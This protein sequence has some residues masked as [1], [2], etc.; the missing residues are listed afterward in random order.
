MLHHALD[1]DPEDTLI[2]VWS[3]AYKNNDAF[4]AHLANPEIYLYL[5]EHPKLTDDFPV[6]VYG[7]VG[8][9]FRS[10]ERNRYTFN[11]F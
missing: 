5:Q 2:F 11:V 3:E 8:K 1:Q 7:T 6:E 9:L 4:L 10:Y